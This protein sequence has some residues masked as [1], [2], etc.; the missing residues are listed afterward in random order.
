MNGPPVV[1]F[2]ITTPGCSFHEPGNTSGRL[3]PVCQSTVVLN[4]RAYSWWRTPPG[5]VE[6]GMSNSRRA[7]DVWSLIVRLLDQFQRP[8]RSGVPIAMSVARLS[9]NGCSVSTGPTSRSRPGLWNDWMLLNENDGDHVS[10][11]PTFTAAGVSVTVGNV[12]VTRP[13]PNSWCREPPT[14]SVP[15]SNC[16]L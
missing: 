12:C 4:V 13:L 7:L 16:L 5:A 15:Q 8:M 14:L 3:I 1:L 6:S 9:K 2:A 10:T 11:S